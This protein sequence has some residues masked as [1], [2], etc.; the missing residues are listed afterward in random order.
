M[1]LFIYSYV[2]DFSFTGDGNDFF[3]IL[4]IPMIK[5]LEFALLMH[6]HC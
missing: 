3:K 2:F 4:W 1:A 5:R 6:G